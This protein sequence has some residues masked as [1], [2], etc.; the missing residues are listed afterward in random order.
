MPESQS[1]AVIC[2]H[3]V[4]AYGIAAALCEV[5]WSGPIVCLKDRSHGHVLMELFGDRVQVWETALRAP[6][7]VIDFLAERIPAADEKVVFFTNECFHHA[8]RAERDGPRLPNARFFLGA[9]EQLDTVLDRYAFYRFIGQREIANV[10]RTIPG[11]ADPW[12]VFPDGFCM[13]LKRSWRGFVRLRGVRL[14]TNHRQWDKAIHSYRRYGYSEDEWCYQEILSVSARH[15]VS[16]CGWHDGPQQ[17]YVATRKVLQ[18][19]ARSGNADVCARMES[20]AG[21][22]EI[23][24]RLL[25]ALDYAGPFELE[26][27][28][29]TN[30]G[31]YKII[32]LN[33]RFWLQHGLV[34]ALSGQEVVRRY[35]GLPSAPEAP[36]RSPTYWINTVY[37]MFRVLRGDLRVLRYLGGSATVCAP[38]PGLALRWIPRFLRKIPHKLRQYV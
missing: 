36:G 21:L 8:F 37:A 34:G 11:D 29:D 5:G 6:E 30:T 14:I 9:A 23:T 20:P 7:D 2:G 17:T 4:N 18:H 13:R 32:E 24:R 22:M 33:P 16:V 15:N 10:P 38:S 35:A 3:H 1:W 12:S 31:E 28:L 26:F 27:L 25:D 19:P